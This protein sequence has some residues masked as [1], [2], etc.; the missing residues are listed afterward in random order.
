MEVRYDNTFKKLK[1]LVNFELDDLVYVGNGEW[2]FSGRGNED[3]NGNFTIKKGVLKTEESISFI[4]EYQTR[5]S[6]QFKY[7]G[8]YSKDLQMYT[9]VYVKKDNE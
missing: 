7:E 3:K 8:Q 6:D 1:F 5:N 2:R 9:G 4:K